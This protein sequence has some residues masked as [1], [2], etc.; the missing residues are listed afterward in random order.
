VEA[1]GGILALACDVEHAAEALG[2]AGE[3]VEERQPRQVLGLLVR[4]LHDLQLRLHRR[5][6]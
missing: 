1:S 5:A 2:V 4:R 3:K 6:S